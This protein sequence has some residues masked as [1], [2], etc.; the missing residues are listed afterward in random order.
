MFPGRRGQYE[1]VEEGKDY[2]TVKY[3]SGEWE[4]K[5]VRMSKDL[6]NR[7]QGNIKIERKVAEEQERQQ[8]EDTLDIWYKK[9]PALYKSLWCQ[10]IPGHT[11]L[12]RLEEDYPEAAYNV[13]EAL[14]G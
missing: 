5:T 13:R 7:L 14:D 12:S 2:L 4:G 9:Y 8:L 6:H 3:I 1:V 11:L 10:N